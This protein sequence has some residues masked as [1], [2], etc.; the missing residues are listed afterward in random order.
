MLMAQQATEFGTQKYQIS[1][2]L[3]SLIVIGQVAWRVEG[4]HLGMLLVLVLEQSPGNQRNKI[5]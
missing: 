5:Q 1:D 3:V 2:A 4:A